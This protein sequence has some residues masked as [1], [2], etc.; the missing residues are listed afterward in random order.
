M[1]ST[2]STIVYIIF[3]SFVYIIFLSFVYIIFLSFQSIHHLFPVKQAIPLFEL[4]NRS[5][6]PKKSVIFI[7]KGNGR[8]G[9]PMTQLSLA[10][11]SANPGILDRSLT[12]L[13]GEA[14]TL[15]LLGPGDLELLGQFFT[16]LSEATRQLY[17]PHP[18]NFETARQLCAEI[19]NTLVMRFIALSH[20]DDAPQII[21]YFIVWPGSNESEERRY[22]ER[23]TPLDSAITCTL[24]PSVADD[25]QSKGVGTSLMPDI[26]KIMRQLGKRQMVLAG[27]TRAINHR[28]IRFYEKNG[29]R[30]I[31]DFES[32]GNNHDMLLEL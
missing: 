18:F 31:G 15:R 14:I 1:G 13:S 29:F 2:H 7:S 12:L 3:L 28:A 4:T 24:A 10:F 16:G 22:A 25:Y 26:L 8:K 21:A 6:S 27:G 32:S 19:D 9:P 30:K 5:V 11:I 17:A 20:R 23:N